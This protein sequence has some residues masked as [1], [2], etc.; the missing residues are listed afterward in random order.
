MLLYQWCHK[1]GY[2]IVTTLMSFWCLS[3]ADEITSAKVLSIPVCNFIIAMVT[4]LRCHLT[5]NARGVWLTVYAM[6]ISNNKW[7]A[8]WY[9]YNGKVRF[10]QGE[11]WAP[12]FV[13]SAQDSVTLT[14][15]ASTTIRLWEI[16]TFFLSKEQIHALVWNNISLHRK[17]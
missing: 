14:S 7:D 13:C 5:Y 9:S 4:N 8:T 16:L 6:L 10:S 17:K 3:D 12:P 15:T 2:V 11:G 1:Y